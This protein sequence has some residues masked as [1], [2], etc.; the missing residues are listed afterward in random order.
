MYV[1]NLSRVFGK[2]ATRMEGTCHEPGTRTQPTWQ[3]PLCLRILLEREGDSTPRSHRTPSSTR[4][5]GS[6]LRAAGGGTASWGAAAAALASA[7]AEKSPVGG[8]KSP[9]ASPGKTGSPAGAAQHQSPLSPSSGAAS[10][11]AGKTP[12]GAGGAGSAGRL[13]LAALSE[14]ELVYYLKILEQVAPANSTP[15]K[16][17]S[18]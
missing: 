10:G 9:A 17:H 6:G 12:G 8:K 4:T 14:M 7:S 11:G 13:R 18:P 15:E 2:Y 1:P 16:Y 3:V 5:P